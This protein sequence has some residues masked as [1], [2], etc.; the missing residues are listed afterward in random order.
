[1]FWKYFVVVSGAPGEGTTTS[2]PPKSGAPRWWSGSAYAVA[3]ITLT[4]GMLPGCIGGDP[5]F[6]RPRDLGSDHSDTSDGSPG[7]DTVD[8]LSDDSTR[9]D[10]YGDS[11]E[12]GEQDAGDEPSGGGGAEVSDANSDAGDEPNDAADTDEPAPQSLCSFDEH[13]CNGECVPRD[14][15][16]HC[17]GCDVQCELGPAALSLACVSGSCVVTE[18]Q[19]GRASC[20]GSSATGC[21]AD[22]SSAEHCGRCGRSCR[23]DERC[24]EQGCVPEPMRELAVGRRGA[25]A[26]T[27]SGAVRCWGQLPWWGEPTL[28]A[29]LLPERAPVPNGAA[30]TMLLDDRGLCVATIDAIHC[31]D[32]REERWAREVDGGAEELGRGAD[33]VTHLSPGLGAD[34]RCAR[35]SDE[36]RCWEPN[37]DTPAVTQAWGADEVLI[38]GATCWQDGGCAWCTQVEAAASPGFPNQAPATQLHPCFS[39][40][41]PDI[42]SSQQ[43]SPGASI[44]QQ[45]F[46]RCERD[47]CPKR[48]LFS[49]LFGARDSVCAWVHK[50]GNTP[51]MGHLACFPA[52]NAAAPGAQLGPIILSIS[53]NLDEQERASMVWV[54]SEYGLRCVGWHNRLSCWG[55]SAKGEAG[56]L[57]LSPLSPSTARSTS[58]PEELG[59]IRRADAGDGFLCALVD[60]GEV[61]C[62]GT[63][64]L[65]QLGNLSISSTQHFSAVLRTDCEGELC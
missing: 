7:A 8:Q 27:A 18:C 47:T 41:C 23:L 50:L 24:G 45:T 12:Q 59:R 35:L 10:T 49:R 62:R 37:R 14:S 28:G 2:S 4:L 65:G 63:N 17:G 55:E 6:G 3:L 33:V 38:N 44:S 9:S 36:W 61:L 53:H 31:W 21:E 58:T 34:A 40:D 5:D 20:D 19:P 54:A 16:E 29:W 48:Q 52:F 15:T 32:A 26:A 64:L 13:D 43:C 51:D 30:F 11:T 22:L 56:Q 42:E 46:P 1:M 39:F 25:C 57:A 60:S